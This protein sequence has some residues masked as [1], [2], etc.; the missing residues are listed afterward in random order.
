MSSASPGRY[1]SRLFNFVNQQSRRFKEKYSRSFRHLQVATKWSLEALLYPVYLLIQKAV[2]SVGNQLQTAET[3][4]R[5]QLQGQDPDFQAEPPTSDIPIQR[6]L[7]AV[8]NLPSASTLQRNMEVVQGIAAQ[9]ENRNLV[10]VSTKNEIFDILTPQQQ[11][12]LEDRII[13][14]VANYWRYWRIVSV[15]NKTQLLGEIDRLLTNLT[16]GNAQKMPVLPEEATKE[17]SR[18]ENTE[19]QYLLN[20]TSA[21]A[22]LDTVVAEL[23]SNALVPLSRVTKTAQQRGLELIQVAKAQLNVFLYGKQEPDATGQLALT[24]GD[25]EETQTP[26]IKAL[27]WGAINY[28]FGKDK[29][30]KLEPKTSENSVSNTVL[31]TVSQ[32]FPRS[33]EVKGKDKELARSPAHVALPASRNLQNDDSEEDPWLSWMDLFGES[34]TVAEKPVAVPE[35][36][37][38]AP[39]KVNPVL[40]ESP[41]KEY[42]LPKL[43]HRFQVQ[44]LPSKPQQATGLVQSKKA[45]REITKNSK[46]SAKIAVGTQTESRISQLEIDSNQG[47]ISQQR[48]QS[49]QIEA[50]SDWIETKVTSVDYEKHFFQQLLESL[51]S[52]MLLLEELL[53][54]IFQALQRFWQGK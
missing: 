35:K 11:I 40:P 24:A 19:S 39:Q 48:H 54:K 29:G 23:E 5:L 47:E 21:I 37:V 22:F 41:S 51:D 18:K 1:Q 17:E 4:N 38:I 3:P 2:E 27:I 10:L 34:E 25:L 26:K 30:K 45:I 28:F 44:I 43:I 49:N 52:V 32:L 15:K 31:N 36:P 9:L 46:K 42:S 7:K 13:R 16:S 6:V 53:V 8:E 14:E 50:N 20:T 33:V 12:K